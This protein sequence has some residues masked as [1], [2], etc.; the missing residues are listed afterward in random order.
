MVHRLLDALTEKLVPVFPRRGREELRLGLGQI[1]AAMLSW[2][3]V[4]EL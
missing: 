1:W 4:P 2:A 3:M